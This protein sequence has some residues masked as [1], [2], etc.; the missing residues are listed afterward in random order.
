[1]VGTFLSDM[2]TDLAINHENLL[3]DS[4]YESES[5]DDEESHVCSFALGK[6]LTQY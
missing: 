5:E 6:V 3:S 2:E 4:D 1:M